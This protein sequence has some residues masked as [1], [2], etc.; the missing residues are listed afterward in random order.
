MTA[1]TPHAVFIVA[2]YAVV[3]VV[4]A[5]LISWV[6]IDG[7]RIGRELARL[8]AQGVRRRSEKSG[9]SEGTKA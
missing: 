2:S 4:I 3:A 1:A 7:R 5:L 9:A 6:I 8:E